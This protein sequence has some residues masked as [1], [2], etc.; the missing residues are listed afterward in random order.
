[1][2]D[3]PPQGP[4]RGPRQPCHLET[5]PG[6]PAES[7]K[8]PF[9]KDIAADFP[10][11]G[12]V[13]CADCESPLTAC[14]SRGSTKEYPY[15]LCDTKGCV[16][17]RK[18]VR[19]EV[20]EGSFEEIVRSLQP[21]SS[22]L[23]V[24]CTMFRDLW[25]SRLSRAL[26]DEQH[27]KQRLK[28]IEKQSDALLE[29]IVEASNAAVIAAYEKKIGALAEERL[30]VTERLETLTPPSG[31]FDQVF[32]LALGFLSNPWKLWQ[33]EALHLKRL[34]LRL[35]FAAPIADD[36]KS[37]YRTPDL[38]LPFKLLSGREAPEREMVRSRGSEVNRIPCGFA[39][40]P[41]MWFFSSNNA[42]RS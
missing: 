33:T 31:R 9:R 20:I 28:E 12:F 14:W 3:Q 10:L 5:R 7:P 6:S 40:T 18:S 16:S 35:A 32:E 30:L 17:Y 15:Y 37:G 23:S 42:N 25:E 8:A 29:R 4:A 2:G 11:R 19:R 1:M 34:V 38:S 13:L 27:L 22:L 36:R 39:L 26:S 41:Q 21:S 24:A